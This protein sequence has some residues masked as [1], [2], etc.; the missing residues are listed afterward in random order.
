[1]SN[2]CHVTTSSQDKAFSA[3]L[4]PRLTKGRNAFA[5]LLLLLGISGENQALQGATLLG[6]VHQVCTSFIHFLE[7][8]TG[9]S[10]GPGAEGMN[11]L[12][13]WPSPAML[14]LPW[15]GTIF[16][17]FPLKSSSLQRIFVGFLIDGCFFIP[18]V[19]PV[20]EA[21]T[22]EDALLW[23]RKEELLMQLF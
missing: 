23:R 18:N 21:V 11:V 16:T 13:G 20:T 19:M 3:N 15:L 10:P 2:L 8:A 6:W 5:Q 9:G 1:M 17:L 22:E 14:G 7:A 4:S 12:P